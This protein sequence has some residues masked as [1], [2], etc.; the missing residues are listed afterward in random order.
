[1][2]FDQ[3]IGEV[4]VCKHVPFLFL[5]S[6]LNYF[7]RKIIMSQLPNVIMTLSITHGTKISLE[8]PLTCLIK[9]NQVTK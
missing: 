1:M 8:I 6:T 9:P 5:V 3:A 2:G 4:L 7:N